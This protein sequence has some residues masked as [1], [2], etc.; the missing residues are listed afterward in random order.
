MP[1]VIALVI[2]SIQAHTMNDKWQQQF[3]ANA[4]IT[5]KQFS[6]KDFAVYMNFQEITE[7][8]GEDAEILFD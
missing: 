7:G 4:E 2:G 1:C 8:K 6:V 5:N 3:I